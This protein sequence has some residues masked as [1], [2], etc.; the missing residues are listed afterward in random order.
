MKRIVLCVTLAL[1]C[2]TMLAAGAPPRRLHVFLLSGQSNMAGLNPDLS[3]TPAL[4]NAFPGDEILVIKVAYNGEPIR[5]WYNKWAPPA[6]QPTA[7]P[8]TPDNG[9]IYRE[10]MTKTTAALAGKPRPDSVTFV[11]MQGEADAHQGLGA[12]YETSLR[13]LHEQLCAD[14]KRA[15][16]NWVIGRISDCDMSNAKYPHWTMVRD[17]Q[18]R[19]AESTPRTA[20]VDTDDLNGPQNALH[21]TKQGYVDLGQRFAAKAVALI[22]GSQSNP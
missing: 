1:V 21:Y 10:L 11:W 4:T 18:V 9:R 6:G 15:D 16:L 5:K 14:L 12:V 17:I 3:F 22:T 20:W 8:L 19:V 13:G 7:A 2:G